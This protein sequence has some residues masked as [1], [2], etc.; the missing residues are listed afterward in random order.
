MTQKG[1]E[2]GQEA[3]LEGVSG[4]SKVGKETISGKGKNIRQ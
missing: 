2:E 1:R 4:R 3:A